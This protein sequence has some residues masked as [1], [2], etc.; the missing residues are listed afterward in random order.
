MWVSS[1]N[2]IRC[3]CALTLC[4]LGT[5]LQ[6]AFAERAWPAGTGAVFT[7]VRPRSVSRAC[8]RLSDHVW[9]GLRWVIYVD[10]ALQRCAPGD[11]SA[12]LMHAGQFCD[13]V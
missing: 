9:A 4:G 11:R 2:P 1:G 6:D 13:G 8:V 10:G 5:A 3:R 7:V 12:V